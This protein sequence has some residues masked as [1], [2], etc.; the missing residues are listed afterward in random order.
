MR[1]VSMAT[2]DELITALS[3]RYNGSDRDAKGRI[4]DEFVAITGYHRKH[5]MR[6]LRGGTQRQAE[7]YARRRVYDQAA[8][9]AI[10]ALWEASD[11]VCGKRLKA[12]IPVLVDA[13]ERHGH[14]KLEATVREGVLT[15]SAATIDRRLQPIRARSGHR[16]RSQSWGMPSLRKSI[17]VRPLTDWPNPV[18]GFIEADLVAHCGPHFGGRFIHTLVLTDVASGWTECAALLQRDQ[19]MVTAALDRLRSGFPFPILGFDT[20]NDSVFINETVKSYCAAHRIEFTRSRPYRKNDQAFVE[21]KNG[22]VVRRLVGY[23]RLEGVRILRHLDALYRHAR[24]FVNFFQPSFK[25]IAKDREG[26]VVRKRYLSPATPC[27][28]LLA[29]P[30]T[31]KRRRGKLERLQGLLDP[32]FLLRE[33]RHRQQCLISLVDK[34]PMTEIVPAEAF[35]AQLQASWQERSPA[36]RPI[37]AA[38]KRMSFLPV[39]KDPFEACTEELRGWVS[40]APLVTG[41]ELLQRLQATYPGAYPDHCFRTLLRRLKRWREELLGA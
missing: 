35:F 36:S 26:A 10:V 6:V 15:M 17:P 22:S 11:R 39:A 1:R 5:A 41:R 23:R 13:L 40:E 30:N 21:Q 9:D 19:H 37:D 38:R 16:R 3:D 28:R 29:D 12:L 31:P 25:L 32:V 24:L 18:P 2:R 34:A 8:S 4:L 33:I 20:D 7:N 14:L 27:Q